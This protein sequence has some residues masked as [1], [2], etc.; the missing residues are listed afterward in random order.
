MTDL[1][2]FIDIVEGKLEETIEFLF[3]APAD[4]IISTL[5]N[6][7]FSDTIRKSGTTVSVLVPMSQRKTAIGDLVNILPGA[8]YDPGMTGSSFGGIRYNSGKILV[9]PANKQ[10]DQSAGVANELEIFSIVKEMTAEHGEI[11]VTFNADTGK[12]FVIKNVI[13]I[14]HTGKET[15]GRLKGDVRLVTKKSRHPISIKKIDAEV[16]ESADTYYGPIAVKILKKLYDGKKIALT[17]LGKFNQ[18]GTE[19][20]RI[21]PEVAVEPTPEEV[22]DVIFG[23]D[24]E[25]LKGAVV[26]Q[27]FMPQHFSRD[28]NKLAVECE[29]IIRNV[30][31]IPRS[32]IMVWLIRNDSTRNPKGGIPGLRITAAV[33]TRAFGKN[34]TKEGVVYVSRTGKE[35]ENPMADIAAEYRAAKGK[36]QAA[37]LEKMA[38]DQKTQDIA[39]GKN[40]T[41]VKLGGKGMPAKRDTKEQP[42][43]KR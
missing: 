16:W 41:G 38:V 1:R 28:G 13:D 40:R 32:H 42:R 4:D 3:E 5:K 25:A 37:Q 30:S 17:G 10:G 43:E 14:E 22:R 33:Q 2:K 20:V 39:T 7:Q 8:E 21:S 11:T 35:L 9:K 6:T 23:E 26:F 18:Y 12:S 31:E 24:V 27:T 34:G 15:T 29:C 19:Y 36:K